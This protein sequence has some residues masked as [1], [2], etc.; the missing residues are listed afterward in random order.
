MIDLTLS[1]RRAFWRHDAGCVHPDKGRLASVVSLEDAGEAIPIFA[2]DGIFRLELDGWQM[3]FN[4]LG[5]AE[6]IAAGWLLHGFAGVMGGQF[7]G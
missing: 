1:E 7:D 5:D 6:A 3:R 2:D 4:H